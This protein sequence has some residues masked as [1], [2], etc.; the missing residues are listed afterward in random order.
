MENIDF[1]N[2]IVILRTDYNV[3]VSYGE[4]TSTLR[5]DAS[6]R[7]KIIYY[8]DNQNVSSLFPIWDDQKIKSPSSH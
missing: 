1:L 6:L 2:K 4:I 3:P 7:T 5:I 8:P